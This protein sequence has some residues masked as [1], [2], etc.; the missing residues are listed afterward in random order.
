MAISDTTPSISYTAS[1]AGGVVYSIP[2]VVNDATTVKLYINGALSA[3]GISVTGAGTGTVTA[4]TNV[5]YTAGTTITFK[6]EVAYE[7]QTDFTEG[8]AYPAERI[9]TGLDN[10]VM[11]VQQV[12][13]EIERSVTT[14]PGKTAPGGNVEQ[15]ASTTLGQDATGNWE[16]RTAEEQRT[17][18][19]I[20]DSV[21]AAATSATAA[22]TS[23]T[24]AA[25]S[26]SAA[27]TAQNAAENAQTAAQ[28]AEANAQTAE[29]NAATTVA[30]APYM[31]KASIDIEFDDTTAVG[32]Q[33]GFLI[34]GSWRLDFSNE[35]VGAIPGSG[36]FLYNQVLTGL[37]W[38]EVLRAIKG[39]INTGSVGEA[40]FS[41]VN[42]PEPSDDVEAEII[43][44]EGSRIY[45]RLT[46]KTAGEA[47]NSI[48]VQ[49]DHDNAT[50]NV[51]TTL[52]GA[53]NE[54]ILVSEAQTLSSSEKAQVRTNLDLI[55]SAA[56][57]S[58]AEA[59][60]GSAK[61]VFQYGTDFFWISK[62][63]AQIIFNEAEAAAPSGAEID[64]YAHNFLSGIW[65]DTSGNSND[66]T[67]VSGQ[68]NN[69]SL[70]KSK[71]EFTGSATFENT[72]YQLPASGDWT[73]GIRGTLN[74]EAAG[75]TSQNILAQHTRDVGSSTGTLRV[76][77]WHASETNALKF[78]M[79]I[80]GDSA[81]DLI[82]TATQAYGS[83][84]T[85][86]LQRDGTTYRLIHNGTEV[87]NTIS[88][89]TFSASL[90]MLLG[91]R[92]GDPMDGS[93]E[94]VI[95]Y[96][97]ALDSTGRTNLGNYLDQP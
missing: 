95:I 47:G 23:A 86:I 85:L 71:V 42:S 55:Q 10:I 48:A 25:S 75:A 41:V 39:V 67:P 63:N 9:E 19:G 73:I 92:T 46:A 78:G 51:N 40:G 72:G 37:G 84:Y 58:E 56:G 30:A 76:F 11:Q 90:P 33:E 80:D 43:D 18:L 82:S 87:T 83:V 36:M 6:R 57:A 28:A 31:T 4:T 7:Q 91:Y 68:E 17:H 20:Q 12:N 66:F 65:S 88:G 49:F 13:E 50:H 81:D 96:E 53:N 77:H 45:L 26:A 62:S 27:A 44:E 35:H 21:D 61:L 22:A 5:T 52:S 79:R 32:Q 15:E 64:L 70:V 74:A 29:A 3:D 8:E 14:A 1:G 60:P 59:I 2:F 89:F 97:S 34:I 93:L 24:A 94:K 38:I 69:V 54:K 16:N